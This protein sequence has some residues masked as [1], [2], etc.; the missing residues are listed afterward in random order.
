MTSRWYTIQ[1]QAQLLE[2][3]SHHLK[4]QGYVHF[5]PMIDRRRTEKAVPV[6]E[7][8]FKGYG[9]VYFD[10]TTDQ[11]LSIN[12]TRGVLGLLPRH[13]EMPTP[14]PVGMVEY[15]QA[16][17]PVRESGFLAA[18][19]EYLPGVTEVEVT[20]PGLLEGRRGL[21]TAV[22]SRLLEICFQA[23]TNASRR[24]T[25]PTNNNMWIDRDD[26]SPVSSGPRNR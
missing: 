10:I 16:N 1:L 14:M 4:R 3:A 19:D 23:E 17:D 7:P 9:F 21:V 15:F 2:T 12:G 6:I 24:L 13:R 25:S 18:F 5:V 22:R 26:V 8:M 20:K 11:W